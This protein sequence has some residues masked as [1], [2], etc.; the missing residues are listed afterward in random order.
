MNEYEL[1][2]SLEP[3]GFSQAIIAIFLGF[4]YGC[5]RAA[6]KDQINGD[7]VLVLVIAAAVCVLLMLLFLALA[8]KARLRVNAQGVSTRSITGKEAKLSW[9][10]MRTA[11]IVRINKRDEQRM[12]LLS[13]KIPQEALE[14]RKAVLKKTAKEGGLLIP[15]ADKRRLAIEHFLNKEL[16][17]FDL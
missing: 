6:A 10:D 5:A 4:G 8:K 13:P 2:E 15:C 9:A 1:D 11:A 16:P 12:I 14:S 7:N 3:R 17:E